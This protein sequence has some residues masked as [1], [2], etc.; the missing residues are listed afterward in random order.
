MASGRSLNVAPFWGKDG[1]D[2][3]A[4]DVFVG[5]STNVDLTVD[6]CVWCVVCGLRFNQVKT[7]YI[8]CVSE[9]TVLNLWED[10]SAHTQ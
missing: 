4:T 5:E 10:D 8:L 1:K 7:Y 9:P 6:I 2:G 3:K